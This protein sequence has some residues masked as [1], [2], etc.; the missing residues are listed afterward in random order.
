MDCVILVLDKRRTIT[1]KELLV[2]QSAAKELLMSMSEGDKDALKHFYAQYG[3]GVMRAANR[4]LSD[5]FLS[6]DILNQVMYKTFLLS[7]KLRYL[8]NP[9]GYIHTMAYNLAI[10]YKRRNRDTIM[11]DDGAFEKAF[12][13]KA[14][15]DLTEKLLIGQMLDCIEEPDRTILILRAVYG[16][17]VRDISVALAHL[18]LTY[19]Q[20]WLRFGRAKKLFKK[21]YEGKKNEL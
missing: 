19:K 9:L 7:D 14:D 8:K 5:A 12:P 13:A 4:V 3:A 11:T 1:I 6:E 15:T 18:N 21:M 10:D 17:S 20:I 16:Y 2:E